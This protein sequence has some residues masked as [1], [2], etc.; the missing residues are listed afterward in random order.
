MTVVS[1]DHLQRQDDR[2]LRPR[3][4]RPRDR[5]GGR[6]RRRDDDPRLGR[7]AGGARQGGGARR[8]HRRNRADWPWE[9][10]ASLVLSPG[11]P[12]THPK[13]HPI[14]GLAKAAGVE[15]ICDIELLWRERRGPDPL[16]RH[17]RHQRQVDDHRASR[18][19]PDGGR[20]QRRRRRQYRPRRARS[21]G[22]ARR[23]ASTSS[24][25]PPISSTSPAASVPTSRSG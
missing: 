14:V 5:R 11:V 1:L 2:G 20:P 13:P 4:E 17:H 7:P 22:A 9:D 12:L 25:C 21:R 16:R 15:I 19:S 18:P 3:A 8:D 10:L 6:R 23:A 24:K